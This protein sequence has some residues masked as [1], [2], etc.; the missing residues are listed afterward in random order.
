MHVRTD[1]VA[2]ILTTPQSRAPEIF[3]FHPR[4]FFQQEISTPSLEGF[5]QLWFRIFLRVWDD[6]KM[7]LIKPYRLNIYIQFLSCLKNY[8]SA[9]LSHL[10]KGKNLMAVPHFKTHMDPHSRE[11]MGILLRIAIHFSNLQK[12]FKKKKVHTIVNVLQ[13]S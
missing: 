5:S 8:F 7:V 12:A 2:V 10:C 6:V 3:V 13:V 4:E 1:G 11:P 9:F